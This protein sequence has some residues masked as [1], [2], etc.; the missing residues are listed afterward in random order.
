MVHGGEFNFVS[1]RGQPR[2]SAFIAVRDG[3]DG[4]GN[5]DVVRKRRRYRRFTHMSS[6][7]AEVVACCGE[8][9][10]YL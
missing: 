10:A 8:I 3:F 4:F 7:N 6:S 2:G 5:R 1:R 9:A